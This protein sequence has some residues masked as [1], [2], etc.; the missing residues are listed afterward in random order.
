MKILFIT[1]TRIG[2]AVLSTGILRHIRETH[3]QAKVTIVT[4]PL[5]VSLFEAYPQLDKI[6]ALKKQKWN[7]HW[8]EL[9]QQ[10]GKTKW[11]IVIDMRNSAVSRIV[12]AKQRYIFT[13]KF[14]KAG[15]KAEQARALMGLTKAPATELFFTADQQAKAVNIIADPANTIAIG[16]TANWIGKTWD[17]A[18]FVEIA[19]WL[20]GPDGFFPAHNIAVIAAPGE[21]DVAYQVFN[22]LPEDKRIDV[23]AKTNPATAAAVLNRCRFYVGNDSG[24]M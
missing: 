19:K 15:H 16:P 1:A 23:I 12:S 8:F 17:A 13:K 6:I 11:D 5:C 20:T 4:G 3:P 10:V 24:L 18:R 14:E 21:E 22:A 2:D 9:W 7:K